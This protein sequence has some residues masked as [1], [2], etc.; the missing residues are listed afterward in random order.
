MPK[1]LKDFSDK[2]SETPKGRASILAMQ[3][4]LSTIATKRAEHRVEIGPKAKPFTF[5]V[6]S[7]THY[8]SIYEECAITR[9]LWDWFEQEGVKR[10]YHCGDVTEG[11]QMRKDHVHEVHKHGVD[12]QAAWAAEQLPYKKGMKTYLISGNHDAS[13]MKNGGGDVCAH[14]ARQREDVTYLGP[15]YARI[16]IDRPGERNIKLDLMHPDGGCS[17]AI[18]YKCQKIIEALEA[19]TKPDV[20]LIGHFHK[21]FTLPAY[22]G[23]AAILAGCTQKQTRFMQRNGLAAHVGGHIISVRVLDGS[24]VVTSAWRSF[25]PS[26]QK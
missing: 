18:S 11:D 24:V 20:L 10:V 12:A 13:H 3:E 19:G 25:Y 16:V 4:Q 15:D 1:T 5:G 2:I 23:V 17:Y 22:R 21:A 14:I 6:A 8:G 26:A 7:C 9:A